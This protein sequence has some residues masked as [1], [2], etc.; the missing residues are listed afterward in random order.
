[1][2]PS[3]INPKII[4]EKQVIKLIKLYLKHYCPCRQSSSPQ[5]GRFDSQSWQDISV[6]TGD[7]RCIELILYP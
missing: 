7:K 5:S 3:L 2:H 6:Q 4:N 1:M